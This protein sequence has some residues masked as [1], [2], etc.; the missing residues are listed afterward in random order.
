MNSN[1]IKIQTVAIL[2]AISKILITISILCILISGALAIFS[3][4]DGWKKDLFICSITGT[5]LFYLLF[6]LLKFAHDKMDKF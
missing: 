1:Y 4:F 2:I 3:S 5:V 6:R